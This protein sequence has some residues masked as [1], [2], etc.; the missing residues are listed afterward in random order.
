MRFANKR[1][2]LGIFCCVKTKAF[3]TST[4]GSFAGWNSMDGIAMTRQVCLPMQLRHFRVHAV[5]NYVGG[6]HVRAIICDTCD[7]I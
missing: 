3:S 1:K 5:N 4:G 2:T 6:S 7:L